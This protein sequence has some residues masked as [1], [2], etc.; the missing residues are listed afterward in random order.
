MKL[1]KITLA[2]TCAA[3]LGGC[4]SG[5]K[6]EQDISEYL[7]NESTQQAVIDQWEKNTAKITYIDR[8]SPLVIDEPHKIPVK[9]ADIII[10]S[11]FKKDAT[12]FHLIGMLKSLDIHLV[13]PEAELLDKKIVLFEYEG[14]LGDYLNAIGVAYGINFNWNPGNI[15][16]AESTGFYALTI[17]QDKD[18]AEIIKS[19]IEELG[20]VSIQATVNTG[21]ISYKAGYRTNQ[22]IINYLERLNLNTALVS[23]QVAIINVALDKKDARGIDWSKL[24]IGLGVSGMLGDAFDPLKFAADQD[25]LNPGYGNIG[26]PSASTSNN[27]NSDSNSNSN[28]NNSNSNSSGGSDGPT[29]LAPRGT[30]MADMAVGASIGGMGSEIGLAKGDFNL[31]IAIDYLSTFGKTETTQNL[32]LTTLSGKEVKIKS[33]D[34]IPYIGEVST[35]SNNNNNGGSNGSSG[36]AKAEKIETGLQLELMPYF[37]AESQ[38][39][40]ISVDMSVSALVRMV[41]LSAGNQVGTLT[42]PQTSEQEFNNVVTMRAGESAILGGLIIERSSTDKNAPI[43]APGAAHS[44]ENFSRSAMFIMLRPSVTVFGNFKDDKKTV[45]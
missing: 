27:S 44:K 34:S 36:G 25:S 33:G 2:I 9:I 15:M 19:D 1:T 30:N 14:R 13:I 4:A 35:Q 43:F 28:S 39:L 37:D 16:T 42:A 11:T 7:D 31:G 10:N 45:R 23:M 29:Y 6:I 8:K 38:L 40:T 41:E 3:I 24:N 5:A 17:P 32:I 12:M 18:I 26:E 22:R 20:A 21:S